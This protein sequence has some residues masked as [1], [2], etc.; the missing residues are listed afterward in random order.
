V[1]LSKNAVPWNKRTIHSPLSK[2]FHLDVWRG[3]PWN[4]KELSHKR[5]GYGKWQQPIW[6]QGLWQLA[7]AGMRAGFVATGNSRYEGKF[8]GNWQQPVWRKVLWQL[9]TVGMRAGF[10]A[11]GNGRYEGRV[12]G[13]WQ[14]LVFGRGL[15]KLR[16]IGMRTVFIFIYF[17]MPPIIAF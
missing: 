11:T 1:L 2:V 16:T 15:W 3:T 8:C 13:N 14:Q 12:C 5:D 10:V 7:T 17:K 4:S 6:G 9:A